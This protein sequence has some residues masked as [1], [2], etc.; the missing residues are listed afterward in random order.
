LRRDE[1]R[2]Q[3]AKQEK[4]KEDIHTSAVENKTSAKQTNTQTKQSGEQHQE[5]RQTEGTER[6]TEGH[7]Q[8]M[9]KYQMKKKRGK[10]EK[11][12]TK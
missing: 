11:G 5:G 9:H 12:C 1:T 10:E 6:D 8:G 7:K 3:G 4:A 2:A